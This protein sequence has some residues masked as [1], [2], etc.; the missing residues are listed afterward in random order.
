MPTP[1]LQTAAESTRRATGPRP[2]VAPG[3]QPFT[4]G[5]FAQRR[6]TGIL[7]IANAAI[8][9]AGFGVLATVFDF[10]AV[11]DRS[12]AEV[13]PLFADNE[14]AVTG[15]YYALTATGILF[16][17]LA[18]LLHRVADG[19]RTP[20]LAAVTTLGVLAGLA[21]TIG[22]AR[23]PFLVPVL[24]DQWAAGVDREGLSTTYAAFNAFAGGA[25]GEHLGWMLQAAWGAGIAVALTRSG[26][27]GHGMARAG[28]LL[29]V[30]FGA[31]TLATFSLP[32]GDVY[33]AIQGPIYT[34]WVL[35][36][37]VLG[38]VLLRRR[39]A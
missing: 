25:I 8:G 29:S 35:W 13:L 17:L 9:V 38:V 2:Q 12:A 28:L 16:A 6:S 11:L 22:F 19:P 20:F 26:V 4:D 1:T 14:L 18:V 21:Q 30:A 36:T 27:V 15:A 32:G 37:A 10:P 7:A 24:S 5:S 23:W 3:G 39:T 34:I 33:E 31:L